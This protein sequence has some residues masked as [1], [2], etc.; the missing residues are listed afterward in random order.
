MGCKKTFSIRHLPQDRERIART[1]HCAS[2]IRRYRHFEI[3]RKVRP[4]AEGLNFLDITA[5]LDAD[6]LRSLGRSG[7][8]RFPERLLA[9]HHEDHVLRHKVQHRRKVSGF[10]GRHPGLDQIA[11]GA[12]V[13]C[14]FPTPVET[15]MPRCSTRFLLGIRASFAGRYLPPLLLAPAAQ[16]R[17]PGLSSLAGRV[18]AWVPAQPL[19][20]GEGFEPP[21]NGLQNRCSTPELTRPTLVLEAGAC[22]ANR[23][24]SPSAA[25]PKPPE[26]P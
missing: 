9:R 13:V 17:E 8:F 16:S 12:F 21:T 25:G 2:P 19:V 4:I 20:P 5:A 18:L 26:S 14:H 15:L 3:I 6:M 10:A 11:D 7:K 24:L 22:A 23:T 1:P